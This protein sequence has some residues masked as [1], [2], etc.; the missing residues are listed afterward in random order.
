MKILCDT[1]ILIWFLTGDDQL[2]VK[3]RAIIENEEN[4]I[5][6]SLVSVWEISIKR[7]RKPQHISL[8]PQRFIELCESQ[9]FLEYPI[10]QRH[11]LAVDTLKRPVITPEHHDPF[12]KLLIAQAKIDKLTFITHDSLIPDYNEPCIVSV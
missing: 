2:S 4:E 5:Y 9:G 6:F 10:E 1:H 7:S 11:I 8:S 12:D 3:A